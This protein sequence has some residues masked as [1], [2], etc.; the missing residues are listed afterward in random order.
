MKTLEAPAGSLSLLGRAMDLRAFRHDLIAGNIS[1]MDTPNYRS[2]DLS[3]KEAL[4]RIDE[5]EAGMAMTRSHP[6]HLAGNSAGPDAVNLHRTRPQPYSLKGDG[7][8]VDMDAEMVKLAE[9]SLMYHALTQMVAKEFQLF[10][11]AIEGK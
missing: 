1:N 11:T 3:M 5:A 6:S 7:N 8:T 4:S 9:N 2:F 10:T